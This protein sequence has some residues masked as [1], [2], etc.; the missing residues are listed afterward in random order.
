MDFISFSLQTKGGTW[1][2]A[3]SHGIDAPD[4]LDAPKTRDNNLG[5]QYSGEGVMPKTSN[6]NWKIPDVNEKNC[7][8]RIRYNISVGDYKAFGVDASDNGE[9]LICMYN[10]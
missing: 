5:Y 2:L 8:L 9:P 3:P 10:V 6:Y 7:V 1:N 4:C